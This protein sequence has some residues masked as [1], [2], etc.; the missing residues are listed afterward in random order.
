MRRPLLLIALVGLLGSTD[1]VAPAFGARSLDRVLAIVN[2]D[3]VLESE[4][5]QAALMT[6][7]ATGREVD[8]DSTAG[9]RQWDETKHK[10][11]D[12]LID[13]KLVLQ[14]ASELKLQVTSE[15]VDRAL[16]DVKQQNGLSESQFREA[17][18]AQGF[19]LESYRRQL[20]KQILEMQAKN[21]SVGSRISI[22]DDE[23]RQ[24]YEQEVGKIKGEMRYH[25][26]LILVQ[27]SPK[28]SDEDTERKQR[29][30]EKVAELAKAGSPS[31]KELVRSYSDDDLSKAEGGDLGYLSKDDLVDAV[32][33]QVEAMRNGEVRGPI[34]TGRGFQIVR[35]VDKKSKDVMPLDSVKDALRRKLYAQQLEKVTQ[36]W[37]KELRRKAHLDVRF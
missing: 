2:D 10:A 13:E 21:I 34:Q 16:D 12:D 37:L 32:A 35:L 8:F 3:L 23:I 26:Q 1:F 24:L 22:S 15:Q 33:D 19:S 36:S 28:A 14:Q 11:L 30:A 17:L 31:W 25:L 5:E 6:F 7:K 29:V 9:R 27:V 18:K 4:V 20:R